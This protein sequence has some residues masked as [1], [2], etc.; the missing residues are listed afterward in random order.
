MQSQG[1]L[2]DTD[3]GSLLQSMQA[4]RATGTLYLEQGSSTSSLYFLF[5]HLFHAEGSSGKGEEVVLESLGWKD[6]AF[7]FDPRA[8]LPPEETIT[9]SASELIAQAQLRVATAS[10]NEGGNMA[11][12]AVVSNEGGTWQPAPEPEWAQQAAPEGSMEQ[13]E[14]EDDGVY[15]V[16]QTASS[17]VTY[18]P[19][20]GEAPQVESEEPAPEPEAPPVA[21]APQ[22][23]A[24]GGSATEVFSSEVTLLAYPLPAGSVLYEHLKSSFID[25]SRLLRTLKNDSHTGYIK[26][27]LPDEGEKECCLLFLNG[28]L[29]EGLSTLEGVVH[30]EDAFVE[31]RKQMDAEVGLLDVVEI[32]DKVVTALSQFYTG[33]YLY[34][35]LMGRFID[36]GA[37]LSYLQEQKTTGHVLVTGGTEIGLILLHD[38][39]V[40]GSYT[41]N[42]R[43]PTTDASHVTA[44][45]KEQNA[46]IEVRTSSGSVSPLDI[47]AIMGF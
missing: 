3:L 6:G 44:L 4:E 26:L 39:Q 41:E 8:K 14:A 42:D 2:Q 25:F 33:Q 13:L 20:D 24:T 12:E 40:L 7:T 28:D 34:T 9:A 18:A 47:K 1:S 45:T 23:A 46:R 29:V 38:G 11:D 17:G 19:E 10:E 32:E 30:G 16:S 43:S 36:F 31:F 5:G 22:A 37:L 27:Y 21:A 15:H 35:Q